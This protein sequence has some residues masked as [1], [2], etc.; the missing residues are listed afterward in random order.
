MH[1]TDIIN[2]LIEKHNYKTYLEIGIST[3]DNFMGVKLKDKIGV[4]PELPYEHKDL[5][6]TTSTDFFNS[7]IKTFD[8]IFIDGLHH[9]DQVEEDIVNAYS[10]LNKKGMILIHDVRPFDERSQRVPRETVSWMGDVWRAWYGFINVYGH[11]I[12]TE[13]IEERAGIGAIYKN[14][15]KV[16][17]GFVD[18]LTKYAEYNRIK[19][20]KI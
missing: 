8:L 7:N 2:A 4:D 3:G 16:N 20:W 19:G 13:F 5:I 9:A 17:Y 11:L 12:K 18:Y 10:V 14:E 1:R 6:Q 15:V